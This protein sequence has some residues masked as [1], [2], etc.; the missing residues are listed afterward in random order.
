MRDYLIVIESKGLNAHPIF[1]ERLSKVSEDFVNGYVKGLERTYPNQV[2]K[3]MI[4]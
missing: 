2:R 4:E 1:T 3:E